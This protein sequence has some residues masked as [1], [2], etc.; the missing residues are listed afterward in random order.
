VLAE[1]R[2]KARDRKNKQV[3]QRENNS[4]WHFYNVSLTVLNE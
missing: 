1:E 4:S 3:L 2:E